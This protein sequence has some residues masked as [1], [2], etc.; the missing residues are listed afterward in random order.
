[1]QK[2]QF[3]K[4]SQALVFNLKADQ[5]WLGCYELTLTIRFKLR[6]F[7]CNLMNFPQMLNQ[8][9]EVEGVLKLHNPCREH[10]AR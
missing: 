1:M 3:E 8:I 10:I 4:L 5:Y 7:N 2:V 9:P 6:R